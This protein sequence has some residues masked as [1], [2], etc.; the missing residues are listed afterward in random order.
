[1][2]IVRL[3]RFLHGYVLFSAYGAYPEKFLN[4]LV[5]KG[6]KI[7]DT[8][9]KNNILFACVPFLKYK[10][11]RPL[12]K[13]C[14]LRLHAI[15]RHGLPFIL[16]KYRKRI[17]IILGLIIFG[18]ILWIC[19]LFIWNVEVIGC[20]TLSEDVVLATMKDLGLYPGVKRSEVDD[21][22]IAEQARKK[23]PEVAWIAVNIRSG[24]AVV[25]LSEREYPPV[26]LEQYPCNLIAKTDGRIINMEVYEGQ[27][28]VAVGDGVTKG[29]L[30]ISGVVSDQY[31]KTVF[32]H[33]SGS[34][35]AET[36]H[37]MSVTV[38]YDLTETAPTGEMRE[39][40]YLTFF[41]I[42]IPLFIGGIPEG[43]YDQYINEEKLNLFGT[44]L[45]FGIKTKQLFVLDEV[46]TVLSEDQAR[47]KAYEKLAK[48]EEIMFSNIEILDKKVEEIAHEG[49]YELKVYYTCKENIELQQ[50][51]I[52]N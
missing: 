21:K 33:A 36:E 25:E 40:K 23:L 7:W 12:A 3:I 52:V 47:E 28:A 34:I 18:V 2:F 49:S 13:K 50:E 6:I 45:P 31:G 20:E 10:K 27:A 32:K 46:N 38:P 43:Q 11:L 9:S 30:L 37:N 1:M 42:D 24:T 5:Q 51:F 14:G 19:S 44:D 8:Y 29:D 22:M 15:E 26:E 39:Y 41:G 17:G 48:E 35:I 4:M 16:Y